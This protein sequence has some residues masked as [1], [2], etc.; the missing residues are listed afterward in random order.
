MHN[1]FVIQDNKDSQNCQDT[2]SFPSSAQPNQEKFPREQYLND[3]KRGGGE[4]E[5]K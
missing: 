3:K 5:E 4:K 1:F 2:E